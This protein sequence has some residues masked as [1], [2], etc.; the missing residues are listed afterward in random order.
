MEHPLGPV[1]GEARQEG[2]PRTEDAEW[3]TGAGSTEHWERLPDC[4]PREQEVHEILQE[5]PAGV[6]GEGKGHRGICQ[7][8]KRQEWQME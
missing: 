2:Y 1:L 3:E 5:T 4:H 7:P 8:E 6:L